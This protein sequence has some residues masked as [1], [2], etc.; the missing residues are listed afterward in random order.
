MSYPKPRLCVP[1]TR[2]FCDESPRLRFR[3]K[4]G[5]GAQ[6]LRLQPVILYHNRCLI[7]EQ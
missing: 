2:D 3:G 7:I 4:T 1:R 6:I 5:L